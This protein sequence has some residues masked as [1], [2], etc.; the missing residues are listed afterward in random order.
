MWTFLIDFANFLRIWISK[1]SNPLTNSSSALGLLLI[2]MK[3]HC[4]GWDWH[5]MAEWCHFN[6]FWLCVCLRK[7][8][9]FCNITTGF[10]MIWCL[11]N[12]CRNSRLMMCYY[13][14]LSTIVLLI[15]CGHVRNL[16]QPI[17]STSQIW[18]V[19]HRQYGISVL[20]SLMSFRRE[21]SGCIAKCPLFSQVSCVFKHNVNM[22]AL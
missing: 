21:T 22:F 17:R 20:V 11:R 1:A 19:T 18:V 16:L 3:L 10:P 6:H 7:Q 4:G 2:S 15:I 14:D 9:T 5:S 13:W 12:E 8:P